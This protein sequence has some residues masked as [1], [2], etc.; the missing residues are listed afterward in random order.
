MKSLIIGVT[1]CAESHLA[2]YLL[3]KGYKVIGTKRKKKF[4]Q[5]HRAYYK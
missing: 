1:G 2:E 5:Q 4:Y 3:S